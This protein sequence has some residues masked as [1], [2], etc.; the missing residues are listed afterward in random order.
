MTTDRWL[1]IAAQQRPAQERGQDSRILA[2]HP[3]VPGWG[4]PA[5]T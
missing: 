4:W 1:H 3:K 2:F 5:K